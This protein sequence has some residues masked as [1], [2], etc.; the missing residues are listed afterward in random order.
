VKKGL[1][2]GHMADRVRVLLVLANPKDAPK[3]A[4]DE[5]VRIIAERLSR[6]NAAHLFQL[7][8]RSSTR[9]SDLS[10]YLLTLRPHILHFSG[11][12]SATGDLSVES[13]DGG[14]NALRMEALADLI[15]IAGRDLR[16]VVLN[17]CHSA[18]RA[19]ALLPH[20]DG[21]VG[22]SRAIS[23]PAALRFAAGFYRGLAHGLDLPRAFQL[24]CNEVDLVNLPESD[25]P[26]LLLNPERE[27]HEPVIDLAGSSSFVNITASAT[28][29]ASS[30]LP[31]LPRTN[32]DLA[33]SFA[34]LHAALRE[35]HEAYL[36]AM[37]TDNWYSHHA[38][39]ESI[40]RLGHAMAP[41]AVTLDIWDA[42]ALSHLTSYF[43]AELDSV[44][45][46]AFAIGEPLPRSW[47]GTISDPLLE[48]DFELA[49]E[50]LGD[51]IRNNFTMDQIFTA[52][53][54]S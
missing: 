30:S 25:T 15:G 8:P 48:A 3:L 40:N 41:L 37:T 32:S 42:E 27:R 1:R 13:D 20:L 51:F 47:R 46:V 52:A 21:V 31:D 54:Q 6:A 12:G 45:Q 34:N 26:V 22:T 38:W 33:R 5:E 43:D 16:Y 39:G 14:T 49:I 2:G 9:S 18:V 50:S 17:A 53:S 4:L 44:G 28:A 10:D 35:C 29:A 36:R 24:G 7:D 19:R 23:D 11:H